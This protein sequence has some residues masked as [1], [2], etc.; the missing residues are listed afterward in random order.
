MFSNIV[1][2]AFIVVYFG[3]CSVTY[4]ET[5]TID[6]VLV[7]STYGIKRVQQLPRYTTMYQNLRIILEEEIQKMGKRCP[8][9]IVEEM[10]VNTPISDEQLEQTFET[11]VNNS[12]GAV[13]KEHG[14]SQYYKIDSNDR[15]PME[16]SRSNPTYPVGIITVTF[17]Y[18]QISTMNIMLINRNEVYE[19]DKT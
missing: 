12:Y 17:T 9:Y 4:A 15:N 16:G 11:W 14:D 1:L 3:T 19:N 18:R 8:R 5:D 7:K 13:K 10:I 6:Y 2:L